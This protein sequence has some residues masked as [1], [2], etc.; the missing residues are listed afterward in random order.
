MQLEHKNHI[1][2]KTSKF[3]NEIKKLLDPNSNP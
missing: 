3:S 1:D 2:Q